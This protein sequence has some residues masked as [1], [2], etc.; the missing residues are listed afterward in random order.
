MAEYCL[1]PKA[2]DDMENVWLYSL[3]EWGAEQTQLY[4]DSL[5]DGFAFLL[6]NPATGVV[7]YE[8]REGLST[9]SS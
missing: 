2:R 6:E 9:V 1:T 3:S 5:S 4:I 7:C 8:I